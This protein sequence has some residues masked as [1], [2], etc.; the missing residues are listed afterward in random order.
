VTCGRSAAFP[1]KT[2]HYDITEILL[3]VALN[4]IALTNS[5]RFFFHIYI[6]AFRLWRIYMYKNYMYICMSTYRHN[7]ENMI[8]GIKGK[9]NYM[10]W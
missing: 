8:F 3:K 7:F 5:K 6:C 4:T 10:Y 1:D 9:C 2:D